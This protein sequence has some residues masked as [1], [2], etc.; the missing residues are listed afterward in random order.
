[1]LR[2]YFLQ[3]LVIGSLA[4]CLLGCGGGSDMNVAE[5]PAISTP[6]AQP[7]TQPVIVPVPPVVEASLPVDAVIANM[8]TASANEALPQSTLTNAWLNHSIISAAQ[9]FADQLGGYG[10]QFPGWWNAT[11]GWF[12]IMEGQHNTATNSRVWINRLRLYVLSESTRTWQL[13]DATN[14]P[15]TEAVLDPAQEQLIAPSSLITA[16]D[17]LS[18]LL[19]FPEW[20]HG[21]GSK[22]AI[23]GSDVRAIFASVDFGLELNDPNGMDDRDN[24]EYLV[25]AGIDYYPALN[26][27]PDQLGGIV[28]AAG[29][30]KLL[31]AKSTPRSATILVPNTIKGCDFAEIRKNPP[32]LTD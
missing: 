7:A 29:N 32:P 24:A 11:I 10:Q 13:L 12:I 9:P 5:Q 27:T 15:Y 17:H 2:H 22:V 26:V 4:C 1:M 6:V 20:A 14:L 18:V 23:D 30:G 16:P 19:Q 25:G 8:T 3:E 28:P 21:F 31:L